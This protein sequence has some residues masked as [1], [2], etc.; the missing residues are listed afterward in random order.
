MKV[1]GRVKAGASY[2]SLVPCGGARSAPARARERLSGI[3]DG[4]EVRETARARSVA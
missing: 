2:S 1:R 3:V 4:E